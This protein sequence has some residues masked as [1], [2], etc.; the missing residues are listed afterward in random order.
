MNVWRFIAR[1]IHLFSSDK[2]ELSIYYTPSAV[3]GPGETTGN[4]TES[5]FL[6][7]HIL[8]RELWTFKQTD[9]LWGILEF[10]K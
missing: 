9:K 3:L 2:S 6:S 10:G 1:E 5:L 7:V 4:K 8:V